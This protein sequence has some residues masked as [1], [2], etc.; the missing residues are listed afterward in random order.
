MELAVITAEKISVMFVMALIGMICYRIG[1]ISGHTNEKL[2]DILLLLVSPLLI[3]T[4]Y[5]QAFDPEKLNGL[6]A[7]FFMAAVSHAVAIAIASFLVK[8]GST[9]W[10]VERIS[11]IYSNCG[12]MGIPLVSA[13]FGADGV[14]YAT[15]Y[16][17]VFN[18]LVW[19]HGV[20]L[21]T[22]KQD[23][24]SFLT[25]L[26][27]P[28]IVAVVL[29]LFCYLARIR[30]PAVILEPLTAIADMNTP[31]AMLVAGVSIA[32]SDIRALL[33]KVQIYY[34]CA[35]RLLVI[36]V[37]VLLVLKAFRLDDMV[38][39][40][41]VLAT[42]CPTATTGT[43]FALKF[44]RNSGYASEIFGLATASSIVTIPVMMLLCG[45]IR[46]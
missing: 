31:L 36:P 17:T 44:H 34:I 9:D 42:S 4:S 26:R 16:I 13:L 28:C 8:K 25:A 41:V 7:A 2:S 43:L 46:I 35:I 27:S 18:V 11:S 3:F 33:M 5:Q 24:K 21:M 1:L 37:A 29:G 40:V 19:T 15:A 10:E 12:F 22:G 39:T 45:L 14:F 6:L 32:G 23:F 20:I 30:F 38:T